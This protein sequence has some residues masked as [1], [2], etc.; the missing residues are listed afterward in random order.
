MKIVNKTEFDEIIKTGTTL[1]DFFADWCGPCKMLA[2]VLEELSSEYP[3]IKFIKVNVDNDE[4]LAVRYGIMSIPT[5]FVFKD[6]ELVNNMSGYRGKDGMK[7]FIESIN[8]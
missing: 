2:P 8:K 3:D 4:E 5:I 1:V 6:G 7:S